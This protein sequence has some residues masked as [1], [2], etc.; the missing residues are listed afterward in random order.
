VA[1]DPSA[2]V[3]APGAPRRRTVLLVAAIVLGA[4]GYAL[5]ARPCAGYSNAGALIGGLVVGVV[6]YAFYVGVLA[7]IVKGVRWV[8]GKRGSSWRSAAVSPATISVLFFFA[9]FGTVGRAAQR[10]SECEKPQTAGLAP[11]QAQ[12]ITWLTGW[13]PCFRFHGTTVRVYARRVLTAEHA[14]IAAAKS[15][16]GPAMGRTLRASINAADASIA[17]NRSAEA[18]TRALSTGNATLASIDGKLASGLALAA[19][20]EEDLVRGLDALARGQQT[21]DFKGAEALSEK[22]S[23]LM[24]EGAQ[25]GQAVYVRLGGQKALGSH[26]PAEEYEELLALNRQK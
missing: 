25:E 21:N 24:K 12:F 3:Q 7:A 8:R 20:G 26:L 1:V 6:L 15:G 2:Q 10:T 9:V 19:G 11:A 4:A 14:F 23:A 13:L 18:C 22:G 5:A 17:A 16:N